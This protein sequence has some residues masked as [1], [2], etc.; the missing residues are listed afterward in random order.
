M[1]MQHSSSR[2]SMQLPR[3]LC[4]GPALLLDISQSPSLE[5]LFAAP[6][7]RLGE[8]M[9]KD[10]PCCINASV[11][12]EASRHSCHVLVELFGRHVTAEL[13]LWNFAHG[14][15]FAP[16]SP[17]QP[18]PDA[19]LDHMR[20][21]G[22]ASLFERLPQ[23]AVIAERA[24]DLEVT[25][26][27]RMF[28]HFEADRAA[29]SAFL[30]VEDP[31]PTTIRLG[32]SDPHNG[33]RRVA[34]FEFADGRAAYYKPRSL[35]FE[36]AL[37]EAAQW[38]T[39]EGC[40][41]AP[42]FPRILD[43]GDH[44]WS[45]AVEQSPP[46]G[47]AATARF[48]ERLGALAA[49]IG[50]C[51]G[52]DCHR[53]NIVAMGEHPVLVD[54][55]ALLHPRI[56][57]SPDFSIAAT[58]IFPRTIMG[59]NGQTIFYPGF[60]LAR[61]GE[62][63]IVPA[64]RMSDHPGEVRKGAIAMADFLEAHADEFWSGVMPRLAAAGAGR[65]VLRPSGMYAAVL[66][67]SLGAQWLGT[68]NGRHA[69]YARLRAYDDPCLD[70]EAWECIHA[71]EIAALDNGDVP[72]FLAGTR[73]GEFVTSNGRSLARLRPFLADAR[74]RFAEYLAS[75]RHLP[76]QVTQAATAA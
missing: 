12:A 37:V 62:G 74:G 13:T 28:T 35:G 27:R 34:R 52:T 44:G 2:A 39:D 69:L 6:A 50:A 73:T 11:R 1:L 8:L 15:A 68:P 20:R 24:L 19:F 65:V 30:G 4:A 42:R 36:A 22:W 71:C 40:P 55:E 7:T 47:A 63:S 70:A 58:E 33:R 21:D 66:N 25:A 60:D 54:A 49:F 9:L 32:L 18:W 23:L 61:P 67:A 41:L 14:L 3:M 29:L 10:S 45:E 53:E 57:A 17:D 26:V 43:R 56:A 31:A 46:V 48:F 38:L 51:G 75:C 16:G 5:P 64:L 76:D 59:P 72:Y